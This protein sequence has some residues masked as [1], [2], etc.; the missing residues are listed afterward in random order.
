MCPSRIQPILA[1]RARSSP[2][3]FSTPPYLIAQRCY[4]ARER[5]VTRFECNKQPAD[6]HFCLDVVQPSCTQDS[7]VIQQSACSKGLASLRARRN[8]RSAAY[9]SLT[10]SQSCLQAIFPLRISLTLVAQV[11][12]QVSVLH[13]T[14]LY[15]V[16]LLCGSRRDRSHRKRNNNGKCSSGGSWCSGRLVSGSEH[17]VKKLPKVANWLAG[18]SIST[19]KFVLGLSVHIFSGAVHVHSL[20]ASGAPRA[21]TEVNKKKTKLTGTTIS[22]RT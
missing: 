2:P 19:N 11:K 21:Q 13:S 6:S 9:L 14:S 17:F 1:S 8:N 15:F 3:S 12:A 5:G 22:A 16:M 18:K 7:E 20:E 10:P 4:V